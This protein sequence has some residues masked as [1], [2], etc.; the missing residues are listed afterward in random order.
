MLK[1]GLNVARGMAEDAGLVFADA[2]RSAP[3]ADQVERSYINSLIERAR[4]GDLGVYTLLLGARSV[5]VICYRALD[6]DA[7]LVFGHSGGG[8]AYFL[9]SVAE[10]L[11]S[12]GMHT[13]RSNFNWPAPH[14]FISAAR[15]MGSS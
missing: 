14:G 9:R 3:A 10:G 11:F 1:E 4:H 15:D 12:E 7:E 5:G 2:A 13:V 6:G 8:E